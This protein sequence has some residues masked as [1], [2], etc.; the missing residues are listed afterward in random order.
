MGLQDLVKF[1]LICFDS[2][3]WPVFALGYPLRASIQ[4]IETNSNTDAKK[5]VTYWIIFS[6]ISLFEHAFMGVL[7]WLPFWPYIKLMI[8][9]WMMI[10]HFDGAFYVYNHF[11]HPCLYM[12]LP[13]IINRFKRLQQ[14]LLNNILADEYAKAH[15][16]PEAL[17]KLIANEPKG[18]E[19]SILQKDIKPV[20]LSE[21]TEVAPVN[22]VLC[23]CHNVMFHNS[24]PRVPLQTLDYE[25]YIPPPEPDAVQ[26]VN[27]KIALPE[28]N[29]EAGF[30]LTEIPLE[31]QVQKE[32]TCAMCQVKVSSEITF[33]SHLQGR[34]HM[35][36]CE[37]LIKAK[38]Q[39]CNG[40]A[41]S[42]SVLKEPWKDGS[43][44]N[45][46]ESQRK[47]K[48]IPKGQASAAAS[49]APKNTDIPINNASTCYKAVNTKTE[50]GQ[51]N[52]PKEEL[53]KSGNRVKSSDNVQGQ[54]C[55]RKEHGKT[56]IS[57]FRCTICNVTC[58][59]SEDLNCHLWGRKHLEQIKKLNNL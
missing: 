14:L 25:F 19:A 9:C 24:L 12:D 53:K 43:S 55:V 31:K 47:Q 29:R 56:K 44:S 18:S 30:N 8:V 23:F 21:K 15:R 17:D 41:G 54:Q 34:K 39:P 13:T 35:N 32:W 1:A 26:A 40:K 11:I 49:V 57:R 28:I 45:I 4:A 36:A 2:L 16:P 37:N 6:L 7:Q 38:N 46:Q 20:R 51:R 10:P 42:D 5:L 58:S 48:L 52:L 59:G 50:T 27:N 33:N 22:Q 3:A